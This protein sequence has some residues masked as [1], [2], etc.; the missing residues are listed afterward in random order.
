MTSVCPQC[1]AVRA[2]PSRFCLSCRFHFDAEPAAPGEPA[3]PVMNWE[4]KP[5]TSRNGKLALLA[6]A[7]LLFLVAMIAYG[8]TVKGPAG[9]AVGA[10]ALNGSTGWHT[11]LALTTCTEYT[12]SMTPAE[13]VAA[14]QSILAIERRVEVSDASDGAEFAGRF[15]GQIVAACAKYYGSAPA[16]QF[17]AGAGMAY[18]NDPSLHPVHH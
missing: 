5:A 7:A 17:I 1:G 4:A 15:A 3:S 16:T 6:V 9:A 10:P 14:A 18:L 8:G 11:N 12:N 13:Q 2:G